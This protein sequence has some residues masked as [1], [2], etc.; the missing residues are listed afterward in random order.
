MRDQGPRVIL[1]FGVVLTRADTL[2]IAFIDRE[3]L[4][5]SKVAAGRPQDL[6]DLEQLRRRPLDG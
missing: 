4:I 5:R 1:I 3:S 6:A 2:D